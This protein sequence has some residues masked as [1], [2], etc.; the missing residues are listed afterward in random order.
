MRDFNASVARAVPRYC[1]NYPGGNL[2]GRRYSQEFLPGEADGDTNRDTLKFHGALLEHPAYRDLSLTL[3]EENEGKKGGLLNPGN[4]LMRES[5]SLS[6]TGIA[7]STLELRRKSVYDIPLSKHLPVFT[8][9][10]DD[11]AAGMDDYITKPIDRVLLYQT[12]A[13]HLTAESSDETK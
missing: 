12:I 8:N 6:T 3:R 4:P 7:S 11:L 9:K 13:E 5:Y 1:Q 10:R 2:W